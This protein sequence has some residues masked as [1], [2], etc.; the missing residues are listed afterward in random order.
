MKVDVLK[1]YK[2]T[3]DKHGNFIVKIKQ[4]K[5]SI[6]PIVLCDKLKLKIIVN[7]ICKILNNNK[8]I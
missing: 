2:Q 1:I 8:D 7:D 5:K 4:K 3:H 6:E